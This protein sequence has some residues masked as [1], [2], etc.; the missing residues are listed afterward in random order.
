MATSPREIG[1][2]TAAY[3][4]LVGNLN[5]PQWV[6]EYN[7]FVAAADPR[8]A[9]LAAFQRLSNDANA[10]AQATALYDGIIAGTV[11]SAIADAVERAAIAAQAANPSATPAPQPQ[12]PQPQPQQQQQTQR[13][14]LR[15]LLAAALIGGAIFLGPS[16]ADQLRQE[17]PT[18]VESSTPSAAEQNVAKTASDEMVVK[19]LEGLKSSNWVLDQTFVVGKD[20]DPSLDKSTP[21][22]G[23]FAEGIKTPAALLAFLNSGSDSANAILGSVESTIG[24]TKGQVTNEKVVTIQSLI[25]FWYP[26]NTFFSNG[27]VSNA[28]APKE[29]LAGEIFFAIVNPD[30]G[31]IIYIRS[32]CVNPQV[33]TP[34]TTPPAPVT[35]EDTTPSN[36]V[37]TTTQQNVVEPDEELDQKDPVNDP[38]PIQGV[39]VQGQPD[40]LETSPLPVP[41]FP[42][43]PTVSTGSEVNPA[44]SVSVP[45]STATPTDWKP[46]A[47]DPN[48]AQYLPPDGLVKPTN[49]QDLVNP[50]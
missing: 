22:V 31:K 43:S 47:D 7:S 38:K 2:F 5:A 28:G 9:A 3:Q 40:Q 49:G 25:P 23:A 18:K 14:P 50:Y 27:D 33:V 45:S 46:P 29:G 19:D 26:G 13:G 39:T 48:L 21:G 36:E 6:T 11:Q 4:Q 35:E 10:V 42:V 1:A 32:A 17:Q 15:V 44:T 20:V 8:G 12:Q 41:S 16:C 30:N 34:S 24:L 37:S